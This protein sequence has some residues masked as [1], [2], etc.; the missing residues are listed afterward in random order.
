M[1]NSWLQD[2]VRTAPNA[3]TEVVKVVGNTVLAEYTQKGICDRYVE[4]NYD[5]DITNVSL[6]GVRSYSCGANTLWWS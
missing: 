2:L 3:L 6:V 1:P 5:Q 4:Q